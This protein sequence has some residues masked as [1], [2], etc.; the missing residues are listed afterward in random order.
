MLHYCLPSFQ[1]KGKGS[2]SNTIICP[3]QGS[4]DSRTVTIP[5]SARAFCTKIFNS[6]V[7]VCC[8]DR[9][10]FAIAQH[11]PGDDLTVLVPVL[12]RFVVS[13]MF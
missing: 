3:G 13:Y 4:S 1:E 5:P 12:E 6:V 2:G 7:M 9:A 8:S 11:L 10:R